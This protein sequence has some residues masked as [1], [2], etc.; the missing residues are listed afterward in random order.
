MG[1]ESDSKA[2]DFLRRLPRNV[3]FVEPF[4]GLGNRL[5][6]YACA[7]ALAKLSFRHLVVVW[8]QDPHVNASMSS[9]FDTNNLTVID[10][11]VSHLLSQ[12]WVDVKM[13]DY[14]T[15]RRK[16]EIVQDKSLVPIYI[17]SAYVLQS[18]TRVGEVEI[19][20]ELNAL[21]P[22]AEVQKRTNRLY[23]RLVTKENLVGVHIRMETDIRRDVP[24]IEQFPSANPAGTTHMGPV[25]RERSRCH[26]EAFVPHL[27]KI[28]QENPSANFF[29]ASDSSLAVYTLRQ[30]YPG[31]V[32][33][34]DINELEQCEGESRRGTSCLQSCLAE[35]IVLSKK[36]SKLILSEW[37]SASELIVRLSRDKIPHKLGC[38]AKRTVNLSGVWKGRLPRLYQRVLLSKHE[39]LG[40]K[41]LP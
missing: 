6:A 33:S 41:H 26:Y 3:L 23:S 36:T 40:S 13:Y 1:V 4:H 10:F 35:F 27:E 22:S 32:I 34:S 37:S 7:A 39:Y 28:L 8:I 15:K 30:R 9:L 2:L 31:K 14:N 21:V 11:P 25:E 12:V 29:V 18:Q 17:R 19:S 20:N 24:G 5:R 16:D 38:F